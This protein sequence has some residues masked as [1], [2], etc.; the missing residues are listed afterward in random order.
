MS[1][2][3]GEG[4]IDERLDDFVIGTLSEEEASAVT[5]HLARCDRCRAEVDAAREAFAATA[6]LTQPLAP[7]ASL[8]SRLLAAVASE[9]RFATFAERMAALCDLAKERAAE[10]LAAIDD[11]ERWMPGPAEG[12]SLFHIEGGPRTAEAIVGF[13]R[14]EAEATFPGH[15]HIGEEQVLVLQGGFVDGESVHR[16]GDLVV[17]PAGSFHDLRALSGPALI[18]LVVVDQGVIFDGDDVIGPG[19]PRL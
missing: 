10:L 17:M 1:C 3:P 15:R 8:R 14:V 19:D 13:V 6:F 12:V 11:H 2:A 18:Y 5:A 7:P 9:S 4:H 16:R